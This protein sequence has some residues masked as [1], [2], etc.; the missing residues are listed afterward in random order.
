MKGQ[1]YVCVFLI[2]EHQLFHLTAF[3]DAVHLP[4]HCVILPRLLRDHSQRRHSGCAFVE[5]VFSFDVSFCRA[6]Q[7][8]VGRMLQVRDA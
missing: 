7:S 2:A 8:C 4:E 3:R 5:N 1:V 6:L